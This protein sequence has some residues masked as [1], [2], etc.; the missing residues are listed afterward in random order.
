MARKPAKSVLQPPGRRKADS[1]APQDRSI[2]KIPVNAAKPA[3]PL[4]RLVA[5]FKN[6]I[7]DPYGTCR[8]IVFPQDR[9]L[10]AVIEAV[11]KRG[12]VSLQDAYRIYFNALRSAEQI[13]VYRRAGNDTLAG[14]TRIGRRGKGIIVQRLN[15][16]LDPMIDGLAARAME[17]EMVFFLQGGKLLYIDPRDPNTIREKNPR[18]IADTARIIL[19]LGKDYG[20]IDVRGEDLRFRGPF[21]PCSASVVSARD[22]SRLFSLRFVADVDPLTGLYSRR[23]FEESVRYHL[24][25]KKKTGLNTAMLMLDIDLFKRVN[26]AYGHAAGDR[27]LADVAAIAS[28]TLRSSDL[29][30][31]SSHLLAVG[32]EI[33]RYGG[34]E[35]AVILP[36]S[37]TVGA[38]KAAQRCR[39]AIE[40]HPILLPSGDEVPVTVSIGLASLSDAERVMKGEMR[41]LPEMMSGISFTD[42]ESQMILPGN[43]EKIKSLREIW[44]KISDEALYL[45]KKR[46]RNRI[47]APE[48]V[49]DRNTGMVRLKFQLLK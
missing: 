5:P 39:R 46:G 47:A 25:L 10:S 34:E 9:V 4:A 33:S 24:N 19:P 37:D 36:G 45:A 29:V 6:I 22:I 15:E 20:L 31:K 27:V 17:Q 16:D 3:S 23:A 30:T 49:E 18:K 41:L 8:N 21:P 43:G 7:M 11:S 32:D 26:D 2:K 48:P 28:M 12:P 1:L 13:S 35:F 40:N 44:Q 14:H 42:L 38:V